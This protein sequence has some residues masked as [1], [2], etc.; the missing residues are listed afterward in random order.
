MIGAAINTVIA[1]AVLD[2]LSNVASNKYYKID[3]EHLEI[4]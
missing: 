2:L 3:Y 1:F 4:G